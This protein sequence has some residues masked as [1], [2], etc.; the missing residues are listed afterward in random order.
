VLTVRFPE[1][2]SDIVE[3]QRGARGLDLDHALLRL[4]AFGGFYFFGFAPGRGLG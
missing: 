1:S 4:L 3:P 2:A